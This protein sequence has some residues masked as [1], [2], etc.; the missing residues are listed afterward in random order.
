[1]PEP[2]LI[3]VLA[4][5]VVAVLYASVGH[6][7]ASGYL[8]VMA[9]A[10]IAPQFASS[11]AL[12]LN[13]LVA[14]TALL[15]YATAGH[16]RPHL[17]LPFLLLSVP[18]AFL[19]GTLRVGPGTYNLA[20]AAV[21]LLAAVRLAVVLPQPAAEGMRRP[22]QAAALATGGVLGFVSG[23]IGIGGGIFLSPVLVLARWATLREAAAVSALFIVA[24]SA[25]GI[26]GRLSAGTFAVGGLWVLVPL[27]FAGGLLGSWMGSRRLGG[28]ALARLLAAV[29]LVAAL[30]LGMTAL[31][32]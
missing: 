13:V 20:L 1:V 11:T 3:L 21:L 30:K 17:A 5:A 24:N 10:G 26:A 19:G 32:G 14:G 9:L 29:L 15:S 7:G 25:A 2:T 23:V 22:P 28:P 12:L 16:L 31:A 18:A 27:A 8:A 6:G 4:I